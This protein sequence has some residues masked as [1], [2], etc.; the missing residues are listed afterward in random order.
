MEGKVSRKD[1]VEVVEVIGMWINKKT[2]NVVSQLHERKT[3]V[4]RKRYI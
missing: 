4:P 1:E 3:Y 2:G